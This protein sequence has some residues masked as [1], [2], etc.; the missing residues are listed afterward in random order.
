MLLQAKLLRVLQ[1]REVDRIGARHPVSVDIRI[2]A[3]TNRELGQLVK[4]G[5]FR[6]DLFFRLNVVPL[7]LPPL[8]ERRSD[9]ALLAVHFLEKAAAPLR[10]HL[11]DDALRLLEAND[12]PGNVR[13]LQNSILRAVAICEG[14]IVQPEH[15]FL[16]ESPAHRASIDSLQTID[17]MERELILKTLE[18]KSGNRT[19]AAKAL[20]ISL[21]TLRNK[22]RE[23]RMEA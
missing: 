21:R 20:G 7:R 13:E 4:Q 17:G 11:N 16:G 15:L 22:L 12:W 9:I 1:E 6:E 2:V 23:Y 3:T 14:P 18:E 10:L 19:H 5:L 8:R